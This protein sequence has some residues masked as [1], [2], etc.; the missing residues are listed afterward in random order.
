MNQ[1]NKI[2]FVFFG[3]SDFSVGV[4]DALKEAGYLP[5][6]IVSTPD[7]PRGRGLELEPTETKVWANIHN[8]PVLQPE[9]LDSEFTLKLSTFNFQLFIV[10]SYGKIIPKDI[11]ELP[12]N[13]T[14]NVHP[15]LLPKLRGASPI[16][17]TIL[18]GEKVG[19]TIMQISERMDE[20]PILVQEE[21]NLPDIAPDNPPRADVLETIL[22]KHGGEMLARIIPD[23]VEGKIKPKEQDHNQAT[24]CKKIEK[25]DAELNL[26]DDA[27]E[28]LRKVRAYCKWPGA[29]MFYKTKNDKEIR[30]VVK[31][32]ELIS[33]TF[34]PTRVVPAG[35]KEMNWS[36]FLRGNA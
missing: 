22:A 24:Y 11:F 1:E 32:A 9:R 13:K 19:V 25:K 4:L 36:D 33:E 5:E 34:S 8:I 17:N 28:N 27:L 14:L 3:T 12:E 21:V 16:Q 7:Q 29:Y 2:P 31:E 30:V 35:K 20:G 10:A 15:S 23:W 26:G 18:Q 6:A